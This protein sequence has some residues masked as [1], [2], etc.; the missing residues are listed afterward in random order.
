MTG[1]TSNALQARHGASAAD[2]WD[3]AVAAA[4]TIG[5][6]TTAGQQRSGHPPH[7]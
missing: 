7:L 2:L 1:S 4:A 5:A 3:G 6:G